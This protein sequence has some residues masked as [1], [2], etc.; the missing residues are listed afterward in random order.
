MS[1]DPDGC[2]VAD[3]LRVRSKILKKPG[4][5]EPK[6]HVPLWTSTLQTK[7]SKFFAMERYFLLTAAF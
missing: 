4:A 5:A 1:L 2:L 3:Q 6:G 7:N